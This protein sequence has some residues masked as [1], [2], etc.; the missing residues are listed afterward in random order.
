[1]VY[2]EILLRITFIPF[3]VLS[4]FNVL[5]W[6]IGVHELLKINLNYLQLRG[7]I[8]PPD[9]VTGK[10]RVINVAVPQWPLSLTNE[11]VGHSLS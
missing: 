5:E 10:H 8:L 7:L 9:C 11:S 3:V 6:R 1:M 2:L 4:L